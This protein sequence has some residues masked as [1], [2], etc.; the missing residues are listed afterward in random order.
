MASLVGRDEAMGDPVVTF[1]AESMALRLVDG[2]A[3]AAAGM[4]ATVDYAVW[5]RP[6]PVVVLTRVAGGVAAALVVSV[7]AGNHLRCG[8]RGL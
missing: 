8:R 1:L 7:L 3:G 6:A 2:L 5:R 4:P